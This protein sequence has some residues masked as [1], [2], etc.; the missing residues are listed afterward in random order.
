MSNGPRCVNNPAVAERGISTAL[1]ERGALGAPPPSP[2]EEI[3]RLAR[4]RGLEGPPDESQWTPPAKPSGKRQPDPK[5]L[6]VGPQTVSPSLA[7]ARGGTSL[8]QAIARMH[9]PSEAYVRQLIDDYIRETA[10]HP[11]VKRLHDQAV[12]DRPALLAESAQREAQIEAARQDRLVGQQ[13]AADTAAAL[14]VRLPYPLQAA[15][16]VATPAEKVADTV[17]AGAAVVGMFVPYVNVATVALNALQLATGYRLDPLPGLPQIADDIAAGRHPGAGTVRNLGKKIEIDERV[18]NALF[19]A[20]LNAGTVLRAGAA[21]REA[22]ADYAVQKRMSAQDLER[23]TVKLA[24]VEP[25]IA[26]LREAVALVKAGKPLTPAHVRAIGKANGVL[27]GAPG[28][29]VTRGTA[30]TATAGRVEA[31]PRPSPPPRPP[32]ATPPSPAPPPQLPPWAGPP[33]R[34]PPPGMSTGELAEAAALRPMRPN[35][36]LLPDKTGAFDAAQ[37]GRRRLDSERH[38]TDSA[39]NPSI[40]RDITLMSPDDAIQIKTMTGIDKYGQRSKTPAVD[41]VAANV[42]E[43]IARAYNQKRTAKF[44]RI[45]GTNIYE[46]INVEA[47]KKITIIVQVPGEVTANMR[48]VAQKTVDESTRAQA[49]V[50]PIEV[51]VQHEQ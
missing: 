28:G 32:A 12:A 43:A 23:F 34:K 45:P 46:R 11:E 27:G 39:G 14:N 36:K 21:G 48:T 6:S 22:I 33:V 18:L 38:T 3:L 17:L 31:A 37:G 41:R 1:R 4:E 40:Y 2:A 25:D 42:K 16:A 8:R 19:L 24:S 29:T 50:S 26:T 49:L 5:S 20:V 10:G 44:V 13:K 47:P 30:N 35:A 9:I 51:I 7:L 15:G